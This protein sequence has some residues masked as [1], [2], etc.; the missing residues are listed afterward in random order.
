MS[1][2]KDN[3]FLTRIE[4]ELSQSINYNKGILPCQ[5]PL[6]STILYRPNLLC[7]VNNRLSAFKSI[8]ELFIWFDSTGSATTSRVK[9]P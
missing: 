3:S 7:P 2:D 5:L 1:I 6:Y 8:Y 4:L 9:L